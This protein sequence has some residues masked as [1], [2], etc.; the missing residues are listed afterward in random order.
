MIKI[1]GEYILKIK[2]VGGNR[3]I[4]GIIPNFLVVLG[5]VPVFTTIGVVEHE[6]FDVLHSHK[7][8]HQKS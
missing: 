3:N 8:I 4:I 6:D 2:G 7:K 1:R 5:E